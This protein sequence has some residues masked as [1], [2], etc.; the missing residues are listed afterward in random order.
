MELENDIDALLLLAD[1]WSDAGVGIKMLRGY[2]GFPYLEI[3]KFV[4]DSL[5]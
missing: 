1:R 5:T 2:W 3:K 4:G